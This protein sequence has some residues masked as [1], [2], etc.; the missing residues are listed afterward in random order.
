MIVFSMSSE[1]CPAQC[2]KYRLLVHLLFLFISVLKLG[3]IEGSNRI[4]T[5]AA[6]GSTGA[7]YSSCTEVSQ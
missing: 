6:H 3:A 5:W 2:A 1:M 4:D 7:L